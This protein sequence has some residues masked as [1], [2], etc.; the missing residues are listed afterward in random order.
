MAYRDAILKMM[1]ESQ[2]KE[3]RLKTGAKNII[4]DETSGET[5]D[6]RLATLASDISA[7]VA[8]G[9]T[10]TEVDA[11]ISAA[12]DALI[13][14]AP[15]AYNTLKEISDYIS[16]HEDAYT[17]LNAAIGNKVDKVEGKGLSTNDLTDALLAKL[18]GIQEGA[19]K[20]EKSDTNGNVKINGTETVVYTHPTGAGNLHLPTGGTVGQVLRAGGNGTGT[21]GE[22]IRSGVS[23]PEDLAE[24]EVFIQLV[25]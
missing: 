25:D 17:A 23:E 6:T 10:P 21:W 22:A 15:E 16:T 2:I 5:L 9:I 3:I 4:V 1:I 20:V 13:A 14:D 7:A 24:G 12:I 18:N 11:K 8:G 19:T